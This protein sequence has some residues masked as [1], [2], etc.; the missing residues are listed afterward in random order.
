MNNMLVQGNDV[1]PCGLLAGM[2]A[3]VVL[4]SD[5]QSGCIG[6]LAVHLDA[7]YAEAEKLFAACSRGTVVVTPLGAGKVLASGLAATGD[8]V[9]RILV[10]ELYMLI[11]RTRAIIR[12]L[13]PANK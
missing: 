1:Q 9:Q 8:N 4:E 6:L 10:E 11:S 7:P 2:A 12:E 5:V 13:E 3:R